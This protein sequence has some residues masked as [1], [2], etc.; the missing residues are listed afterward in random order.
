MRRSAVTGWAGLAVCL[1]MAG[2][3]CAGKGAAPADPRVEQTDRLVRQ[4]FGRA[5]AEL[6]T[7]RL[8]AITPNNQNICDEFERAFSLHH[9]SEFGQK[10]R[11]DWRD[12]GGGSTS[13]LQYLRNVYARSSTSELDV[14]WGGGDYNFRKMAGE[15]LLTPMRVPPEYRDNVPRVLGGVEMYDANGLWCGSA[16]SGFGFLYNRMLIEWAKIPP[17]RQWQDLGRPECFGQVLLADP[18]QSGSAATSYEMI[19]QS[20]PNWPAG[21]ARLLAIL[22]NARRLADSAGQAANGPLLG[23]T[24][25]ATCID[26]YGAMRVAEAPEAMVYVS[27]K[28]QTAF[29]PDPIAILRNPPHPRLAQRFVDFVLSRAG[30]A[31]W[32]LPA[33]ADDGPA[34][35]ELGRQ[36]IRR[37]VYEHYAGRMLPW[38]VDPYAA[39]SEMR[40]DTAMLSLRLGVLRQLVRAAAA[41]NL[42]YLQ[43]ARRRLIET[44]FPPARVADFN[45]LPEDVATVEGLRRVAGLL[46]DPTAAERTVTGWQRFFRDKYRRVAR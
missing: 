28:G 35:S 14:V 27:P 6:P 10:V 17:P 46:R 36:P 39:G 13:I 30:Q 42:P 24:P 38:I 1:A 32:A 33:G 12:V 31:L 43:A 8:S 44:G 5:L 4:R 15:K 34:R 23:E 26:F 11:I 22:G 2:A 41:D 19:V 16:V 20:A 37:D 25:I 3:G 40:L 45:K 7:L 18:T 9:A 29:N 21:W